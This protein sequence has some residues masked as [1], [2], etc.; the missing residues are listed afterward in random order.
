M[1]IIY[2]EM[3][4]YSRCLA[5]YRKDLKAVQ[6]QLRTRGLKNASLQKLKKH[7]A[8][9]YKHIAYLENMQKT[10][11]NQLSAHPKIKNRYTEKEL[12]LLEKLCLENR[13]TLDYDTL[14]RTFERFVKDTFLDS[15]VEE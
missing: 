6:K 8:E 12:Q 7:E 11:W 3:K 1:K 4:A 9:L 2:E 15:E 13:I 14:R 10:H 5:A